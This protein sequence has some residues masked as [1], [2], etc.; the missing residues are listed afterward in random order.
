[1]TETEKQQIVSIVL[2]SLKT[3]SLTI[4]QLTSI[5]ELPD[6][7]YIEISGGCKISCRYLKELFQSYLPGVDIL[8]S[9]G[10]RVDAV[11]CQSFFTKEL[12]K[13]IQ[14]ILLT[15][16]EFE[17]LKKK[18]ENATYFVYEEE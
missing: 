14:P 1:M 4:E 17:D 7:A 5:D 9:Y 3:N 2:Q 13:C 11:I 15:E 8:C 12:K 18:D 10:D 6:D 16:E